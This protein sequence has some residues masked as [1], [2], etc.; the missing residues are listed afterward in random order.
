MYRQKLN[1]GLK[2]WLNL[3]CTV[4]KNYKS[5]QGKQLANYRELLYAKTDLQQI[6][7]WNGT[8]H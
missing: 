8:D 1:T 3:L 4:Y 6:T 5:T 2:Q 7:T